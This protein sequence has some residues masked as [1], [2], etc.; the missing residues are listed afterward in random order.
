MPPA[1]ARL[2]PPLALQ[3]LSD[4]EQAEA[5]LLTWGVVDGFFTYEELLDRA[6]VRLNGAIVEG[7]LLPYARAEALV[8][9][10]LGH[11][12]LLEL[13]F[14]PGRFR[15][16]TAEAIRLFSRLRQLFPKHRKPGQWRAAPELIADY[17]V[18]FRPRWYP[19]R[20]WRP[21]QVQARLAG[22]GASDEV[23]QRVMDALLSARRASPLQLADFQVEAAERILEQGLGQANRSGTIVCAGTGSGKT[24]AFYLPAL[25]LLAQHASDARWTR[26][27]ALYPRNELLKDQLASALSQVRL[28]NDVLTQLRRPRVRV[29]ALFGSVPK[30]GEVSSLQQRWRSGE[31]KAGPGW[32]CPYLTCPRPACHHAE[33]L[34]LESDRKAGREVL[35]CVQPGCDYAVTD[36][37]FVLTRDAMEEQRP[38]LLLTSLE[39]VNQYMSSLSMRRLFG[40]DVPAACRPRLMLL[41]EVHTY[42]G[43]YGAQA[44]LLLRRWKRASGAAP[45]FVGLSAT[46]EDAGRFFADLVAEPESA[47]EALSPRPEHLEVEGQ[48]VL[49]ALRGNPAVKA[50]L[51]SASIQSA[52]LLR[53]VLDPAGTRASLYGSKVFAFTDDLDVTNRLYHTLLDAEGWQIGPQGQRQ[54][55]RD[56]P[57]AALRATTAVPGGQG[58]GVARWE[59]GQLWHLPESLGHNLQGLPTVRV[60]R[61]SS[62]DTGVDRQAELIVATAS[63]EVGFDDPDV[64]AVLQHKAPRDMAGF[65]QRKGRAGRQRGTRPWTVVVLSDYG[66]DRLAYQGYDQLFSPQLRPRYLPIRNR[67]VLR[68]QAVFSLLEFLATWMRRRHHTKKAHLWR[69]LSKPPEYPAD[70]ERIKL[71]GGLVQEI[72]DQGPLAGELRHYLGQAL[73]VSDDVVQQ[74]LWTPP[75]S[76]LL[77]VLPT[78]LRRITRE[79]TVASASGSSTL[80]P[81]AF[82]A[83]L[84][85]FI[86]KNLFD[87]LNLP[88]LEVEA[89][90]TASKTETYRMPLLQGLREFAPGRVSRRF[91]ISGSSVSHWVAIA[92]GNPTTS[93]LDGFCRPEAAE[94]LGMFC[95]GTEAARVEVACIRPYR[96]SVTRPPAEVR[97]T[98]NARLRWASQLLPFQEAV[99]VEV[100]AGSIWQQVIHSVGFFSHAYGNAIEVRRFALGSRYEI[101]EAQ[102]SRR[103]GE[104]CFERQMAGGRQAVALGYALDCDA[105]RLEV[106]IPSSL[107]LRVRQTPHLLRA[108][109]TARFAYEVQTAPELERTTSTFDRGWLIQI[110]LSALLSDAIGQGRSLQASAEALLGPQALIPLEAVLDVIFQ[111]A[112]DLAEGDSDDRSGELSAL[113][114]YGAVQHVLRRAA[115]ALWVEPEKSWEPWLRQRFLSTLGAAVLEACQQACPDVDAGELCL[116]IDSGPRGGPE[117]SLPRTQDEV[118]LTETTVGGGGVIEAILAAYTAEPRRFFQLIEAA[119]APS[120]FEEIDSELGTLLQWIGPGAIHPRP[121]LRDA[122]GAVREASTHQEMLQSNEALRQQLEQ[123]GLSISHPVMVALQA[124]ILRPGSSEKTDAI[125]AELLQ[126]WKEL[127]EALGVEVDARMVAYTLSQRPDFDATLSHG[128]PIPAGDATRAWRYGALYG[129]LWPRGMEVRSQMLSAYNPFVDLPPTDR[130]LLRDVLPVTTDVRW[131]EGDWYLRLCGTLVREGAAFLSAPVAKRK[132]IRQAVQQMLLSPLDTESLL[133]QPSVSGVFQ[134]ACRIRVRFEISERPQ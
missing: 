133:V 96:L 79:W 38:D 57:L 111:G 106:D 92:A 104:V 16:R 81:H 129:L 33:L 1:D 84:P 121:E 98:S 46:L 65:L 114:Q 2:L 125:L 28:L 94:D 24:L 80:E 51:L 40:V 76:L 119:L 12:L 95:H 112:E 25:V 6:D 31:S 109:R 56:P 120:D 126:Q 74:L 9:A 90:I 32:V 58:E 21:D 130:W 22:A 13:P 118:W 68:M 53:R 127:E 128:G 18:M 37:E 88:E 86:P 7:I 85:E 100:P 17:R 93:L 11:S 91:G 99:Q 47:V 34:W 71:V 134:E 132:E 69:E 116:D 27:L 103:V 29:G 113:L 20:H 105:L 66:R 107:Y 78:L 117:G 77:S 52:M 131:E 15:T 124:R 10:L 30:N 89:Q 60:A 73:G 43:T 67:Y 36:N 39:M 115:Q 83:P 75:R 102:G 48:E 72:L 123:A 70:K 41:D 63:L 45:Q 50:S 87:D 59:G 14:S 8:K 61:T 44:A 62:Q 23:S 19:K 4:L 3:V 122:L 110:C 49:L 101:R 64:G 55:R 82:W 42:S 97:S 35:R 54:A 26:C 5:E 108:I